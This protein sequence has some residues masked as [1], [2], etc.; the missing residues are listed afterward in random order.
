M[1]PKIAE[2]RFKLILIRIGGEFT[3]ARAPRI[4]QDILNLFDPREVSSESSGESWSLCR[5]MSWAYEFLSSDPRSTT[6]R[7]EGARNRGWCRSHRPQT[8]YR[9]RVA[10]VSS[11]ALKRFAKPS[12]HIG[13]P[14]PRDAGAAVP[15]RFDRDMPR[16]SSDLHANEPGAFQELYAGPQIFQDFCLFWHE[17]FLLCER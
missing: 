3:C 1:S 5:L 2:F 12:M 16:P 8:T 6:L 9:P 7:L 17:V 13:G 15:L 14:L 10:G 11:R 4:C